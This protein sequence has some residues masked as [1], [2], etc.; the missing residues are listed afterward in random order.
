[1]KRT[2][3]ILTLFVFVSIISIL[4]IGGCN[5]NGSNGQG[6]PEAIRAIF[7]DSLYDGGFWALRVVDLETGEVIYNQRSNEDIFIGSVRK[8]FTIGEALKEFGQDFMFRKPIHRQGSVNDE[9]VLDGDI[10]LVATGDLTMGGRRNPNNTM[11][12]TNFDH[13]DANN[14]GNAI[15]S[16]PDPLQGYKDLAKQIADSGVTRITGEIIIDDRLFQP[17]LFRDEFDVKPIFVND[18]VVD[19]IVNPGAPGG[20]A[21]VDWRPK[22]AAFD[23]ESTLQTLALGEVNDIDLD[24]LVP[25]CFGML[26]C[27]GTV[28]GEVSADLEPPLTDAFPIIQIFRIS[29]PSSYARTVLIEALI[30]EGVEVDAPVVAKNPS[31]LLPP[32]NSYTPNTILGE[33]VSLPYSEYAKLVLKVSYNIGSDT[34]LLLW[35]LTRVRDNMEDT[36]AIERDHLINDIGIPGD[37]FM[38]FDGSG[39]GDTIAT[40]KAVIQMLEYISKQSF[41]PDY[42]ELL[43][44]LGVDGSLSFVTDFEE[45]NTLA[46]AKGNVYAKTGTFITGSEEGLFLK[47]Q[48]LG[49]YIDTK[50]GKWLMFHLAVNNVPLGSDITNVQQV[51]QDQ[52]TIT[53]IIWRDN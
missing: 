37:E 25:E 31:Q 41:F 14:L 24:P 38:F 51:F 2:R 5:K 20:P 52:G 23:V 29:D 12:V 9:G 18:D 22:S 45:D 53:A 50:S 6:I 11:A 36:L 32:K 13:N 42:L 44:I 10:I 27:M 40:N 4:S 1:M 21:V 35:G 34:S 7:N 49:G 39:G 15:L 8:V 33:Y 26:D 16:A 43:P 47:G 17:Y 46:G 19:V 28:S 3:Q 48:A 30:E